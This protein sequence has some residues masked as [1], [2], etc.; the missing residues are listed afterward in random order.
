MKIDKNMMAKLAAMDDASLTASIRM[1][2]A[3]SGVDI[4]SVT[5]DSEQLASLRQAMM[6]ATD[7]DIALA[8]DILD[9]YRKE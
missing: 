2:A 4:G 1:I 5:F 6:G 9:G 7:D 3:A 8:K